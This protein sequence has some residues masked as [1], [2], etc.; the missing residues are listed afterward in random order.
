MLS[1]VSPAPL[2]LVAP[3]RRCVPCVC[4]RHRSARLAHPPGGSVLVCREC[5]VVRVYV[6][7]CAVVHCCGCA[8]A[9]PRWHGRRLHRCCDACFLLSSCRVACFLPLNACAAPLWR[10]CCVTNPNQISCCLARTRVRRF[11]VVVVY[12]PLSNNRILK[13][14]AAE[15]HAPSRAATDSSPL[16]DVCR[17]MTHA[18][19]LGVGGCARGSAPRR[20]F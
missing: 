2:S 7:V 19:A 5:V 9:P 15:R 6:C 8:R 20:R 18:Q 10:R 3:A 11:H 1:L 12:W 17:S 4:A 14:A 16:D 13:K